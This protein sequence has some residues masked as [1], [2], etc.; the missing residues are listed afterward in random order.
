MSDVAEEYMPEGDMTLDETTRPETDM[1]EEL[2]QQ[3]AEAAAQKSLKR[4][5]SRIRS[6]T[7]IVKTTDEVIK[8]D[9]NGKKHYR[10]HYLREI[11]DEY[12]ILGAQDFD[13]ENMCER[14]GFDIVEVRRAIVR[15]DGNPNREP[16]TS[17]LRAVERPFMKI[18]LVKMRAKAAEIALY[19]PGLDDEGREIDN[20]Y[21][22]KDQLTAMQR[23]QQLGGTMPGIEEDDSDE[24]GEGGMAYPDDLS[25]HMGSESDE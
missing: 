12:I 4:L 6:L 17:I 5:E 16:F 9:E 7:E 11:I 8:V 2:K 13:L 15:R 19:E 3:R 24:D 22:V 10:K 25:G 20:P 1:P 21:H 23:Y 18:N 14:L